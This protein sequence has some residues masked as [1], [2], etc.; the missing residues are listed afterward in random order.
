MRSLV[1]ITSGILCLS[2]GLSWTGSS[3][4]EGGGVSTSPL[5]FSHGLHISEVGMDCENCHSRIRASESEL[6][7]N[8]PDKEVCATCHDVAE[9]PGCA[10]CHPAGSDPVALVPSGPRPAH[11]SHQRHLSLTG[12]AQTIRDA[13]DEGRYP[14]DH[15]AGLAE[16][17]SVENDCSACHRGLASE[18]RPTE[19][20]LPQMADCLVCHDLG[21][22]PFDECG[23]CHANDVARVPADHSEDFFDEHSTDGYPLDKARCRQCHTPDNNPCLQCH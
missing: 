15:T 21:K 12:I 14:S 18:S 9:A 17:I 10:T 16:Q 6:D 22:D 23:T 20:H 1:A 5:I 11:F 4:Q 2:F 13:I 3:L 8:L 7:N 19:T